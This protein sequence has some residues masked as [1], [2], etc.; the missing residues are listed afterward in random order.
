MNCIGEISTN[1]GDSLDVFEYEYEKYRNKN[2]INSIVA[3]GV[4]FRLSKFLDDFGYNESA[5]DVYNNTSCVREGNRIDIMDN[6][7]LDGSIEL[8]FVYVLDNGYVTGVLYDKANDTWYG[9]IEI[10]TI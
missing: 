5:D 9:E 4:C 1:Y 3:E 7:V 6:Y 2:E 10:S 8:S